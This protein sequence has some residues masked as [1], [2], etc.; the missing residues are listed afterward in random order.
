M[1]LAS[2][3][4]WNSCLEPTGSL[5]E[6]IFQVVS[7]EGQNANFTLRVPSFQDAHVHFGFGS[8]WSA[9]SSKPGRQ[10]HWP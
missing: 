9:H 5:G 8:F 3:K 10:T 7:A 6:L 4:V 2:G 1:G